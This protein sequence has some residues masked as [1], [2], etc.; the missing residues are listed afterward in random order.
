MK[1]RVYLIGNACS[2]YRARALLEYLASSPNYA[3]FYADPYY[4]IPANPTLLK[5]IIF[6]V[7]MILDR[8]YGLNKLL[9]ADIVYVLPMGHINIVERFFIK[10]ISKKVTTEFYISM[11]DT[12]VNDRKT[13][14]AND[15]KAKKLLLRDRNLIDISSI[16]IFLN[17]S[18]KK[19]YLNIAG[20]S[21][22]GKSIYTVPLTTGRKKKAL[23][24]FA[25]S[26]HDQIVLCWWGTL[27][28]L[29]GLDKIIAAAK[30]LKASKIN[31]ELYIFCTSEEKSKPYRAYI[32]NNRLEDCVFI[33]NSKIFSNHSLDNFLV[34]HCDIAFG[35]FGDS[36]KAKTVMVNKIV[37][38]A[39]MGI[40]VIT[41]KTSALNE[42]YNDNESIYFADSSAQGISEK[43]IELSDQKQQMKIVSKNCYQLYKSCFSKEAYIRR[44]SSILENES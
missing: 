29:H 16:L 30:I 42:Y 11:Y 3:F 37:E 1:K 22:E 34:Q 15:T 10:L 6:K 24:P 20:K 40:P 35:N 36:E 32:E 23:L 18:E 26:K 2:S 27:I 39:S 21:E 38:A 31:F 19:F 41:Q 33:D 12:Y 25:N 17:E 7:A 4:L 8:L 44:I 43:I 14:T 28:P 9:L 13:I 5:R